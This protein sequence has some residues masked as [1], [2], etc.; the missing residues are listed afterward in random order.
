MK[1]LLENMPVL[2]LPLDSSSYKSKNK[3]HNKFDEVTDFNTCI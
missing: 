1:L 2:V 3:P